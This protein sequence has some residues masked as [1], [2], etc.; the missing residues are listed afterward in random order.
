MNREDARAYIIGQA[1]NYLKP[2]KS[3][4]GY[5]CPICGDGDGVNGNNGITTKDGVHFTCWRGCFTNA[6]LIDII[7]LEYNARDYNEKLER[8]CSVLNITLD[9]RGSG[10]FTM[11]YQNQNRYKIERNTQDDIHN[12]QYTTQHTQPQQADAEPEPDYMDFFLQAQ[13]NIDQTSYHRG[14]SKG[15]L[16]R[17]M[18][19]YVA[20]WKHSKAPAKVAPT[21][22]LIIPTSKHSYL[23]RD[24]RA[25]IPEAER[26]YAKMKE[27]TVRVFNRKAI[28]TATQPIFIVE[29]EIDA[30]SIC[31]VG[32]EAVALGSIGNVKRL[33]Q[34]TQESKPAQP[35]IISLDNDEKASTRAKVEQAVAAL[36]DGLTEQG[37]HSYISN[38]TGSYKDAN[39]ALIKDRE[40]FT[41]AVMQAIAQAQESEAQIIEA[42]RAELRSE[43][44]VFHLQEFLQ[45]I[46]DSKTASY[47]ATGFKEI[48]KV[49]DGGLYAGLYIVGAISS[50]GKTTFCLQ[51]ADQIAQAGRDVLIFSLEMARAEL[52]AKSISRLT[53]IQDLAENGT[54]KNAKTTRGILTGSRYKYYSDTEK[55][56]IQ[57]AMNSY[58][59]YA[60]HIYMTEGVGNVGVAEIRERVE[61][62]VK[63]T[64][65]APAVLIDYLQIIAPA[66][67]R[68]TDKQNTDKAVLELKR[69]SRDYN[70]PIIGISSFNRDNYQAPVN[71]ASFK[72]SGAIEY[73]SDVLIGLQ[74][75]G[76]DYKSG[77]TD[78]NRQKRI[79][80]LLK[81]MGEKASKGEAQKIQVKVLKNRNGSKGDAILEFY[82]MFN[83]FRDVDT[84]R[85]DAREDIGE[86]DEE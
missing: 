65:E 29:G 41:V 49:L 35:F 25:E 1:R 38:I 76:M 56:L 85:E 59:D 32:G 51:I 37:I 78:G 6:D 50:L 24:T 66:D 18:V 84:P 63:I 46:E 4:K 62:H 82:P 5:I 86:W 75:C 71:L 68:A 19:G 42:E 7:G 52:I 12:T 30:M 36:V 28:A 79:R 43:A 81:D 21:P 22:R 13:K 14:L 70:I 67:M 83:Y 16:E 61:R 64:G 77:E 11:D 54:S 20:E 80:T 73:S 74:Y 60:D 40:A 45:N 58:K 39:E 55:A 15:T 69:L 33:L 53:L 44:V 9:Q 23:A 3:K 10:G 57:G 27:G 47:T 48:D 26:Q 2:D 72:E 34:I 31:D 17:F 8:A